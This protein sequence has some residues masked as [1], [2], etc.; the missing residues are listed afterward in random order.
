MTKFFIRYPLA[1][2]I[3]GLAIAALFANL[4]IAS[5]RE[6][7]RL[8]NAPE[9]VSMAEAAAL[10][11]ASYDQ[12]P[13]V[14]IENGVVDCKSIRYQ[15]VGNSNRTKIF[16]ADESRTIVVVVE[17]SEQLTCQRIAQKHPTG[18]LSRM[19]EARYKRFL[20]LKEF[21]LS[22]YQD[23][24]VFMDLC[25]FCSRGNSMA[26]VIVGG[27]LAVIGLS[28]YPMCLIE[29]HKA[30]PKVPPSNAGDQP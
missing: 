14:E 6:A 15:R 22:T 7:H 12:Q 24:T 26:G 2:G 27:I 3:F 8:P 18:L 29:H 20:E 1:A 25:A 17:Y 30:Y 23:A 11:P 28:L 19:N 9:R 4:A 10:A 13:W 21:D 5:Y 16:V